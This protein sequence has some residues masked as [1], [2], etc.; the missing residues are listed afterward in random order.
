MLLWYRI[1]KEKLLQLTS[2]NIYTQ[3]NDLRLLY[4][5]LSILKRQLPLLKFYDYISTNKQS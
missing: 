1:I 4:T 5:F 2:M 3:H